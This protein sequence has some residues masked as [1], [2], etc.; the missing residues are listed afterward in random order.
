MRLVLDTNVWLDWL[1]FDDPAIAPLRTARDGGANEQPRGKPRGI[2][3]KDIGKSARP[4]GRGIGPGEIK[5][6]RDP[7]LWPQPKAR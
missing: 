4:K 3:T 7:K 6:A 5:M 1:I 2:K